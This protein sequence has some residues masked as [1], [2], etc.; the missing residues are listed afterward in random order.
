VNHIACDVH[1]ES[2]LHDILHDIMS[3]YHSCTSGSVFYIMRK[4]C[5]RKQALT[6]YPRHK[7]SAKYYCKCETKV[8]HSR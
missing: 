8:F 3:F 2:E 1:Y 4:N 5:A 6:N 7:L